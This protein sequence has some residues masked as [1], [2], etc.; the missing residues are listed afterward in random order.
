MIFL[1]QLWSESKN[2][3]FWQ[4]DLSFSGNMRKWIKIEELFSGH[5][6]IFFCIYNRK[7]IKPLSTFMNRFLLPFFILSINDE[8]IK[9]LCLC[10][11]R[12]EGLYVFIFNLRKENKFFFIVE[13]G[14]LNMYLLVAYFTIQINFLLFKTI[15]WHN[16]WIDKLIISN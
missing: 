14:V 3:C 4:S 9:R 12:H 1:L 5:V 8:M 10:Q 16:N 2:I 7:N 15:W 11:S 6:H 13:V